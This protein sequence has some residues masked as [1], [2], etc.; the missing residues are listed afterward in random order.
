M[1][2]SIVGQHHIFIVIQLVDLFSAK[3]GYNGLIA[4]GPKERLLLHLKL[5][6]DIALAFICINGHMS[7]Q[8]HIHFYNQR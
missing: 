5:I 3:N 2:G 7:T 1:I 4:L 6:S 8:A